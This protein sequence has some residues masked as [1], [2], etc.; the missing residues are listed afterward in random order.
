MVVVVVMDD[1]GDE[2][3]G[4]HCRG[5]PVLAILTQ[6]TKEPSFVFICWKGFIPPSESPKCSSR[7]PI[8]LISRTNG[9]A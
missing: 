2:H 5:Q 7:Q 1:G 6:T 4:L 8:F 3:H 9:T